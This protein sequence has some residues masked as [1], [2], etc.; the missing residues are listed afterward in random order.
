MRNKKGNGQLYTL[1]VEKTVLEK[2]R[3]Q[4]KTVKKAFIDLNKGKTGAI[5]PSE[6][7]HYLKLWGIYLNEEQFKLLFNKFDLDKDGKIT[8]EDF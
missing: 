6:L 3:L 4:W 7:N 2:F 1:D 8:Y 5:V